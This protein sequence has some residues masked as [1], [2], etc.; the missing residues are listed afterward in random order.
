[1]IKANKLMVPRVDEIRTEAVQIIISR[2][3]ITK[4]AF[5]MRESMSQRVDYLEIKEDIFGKKT[6]KE[7][8]S[9]LKKRVKP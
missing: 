2:L 6:A 1:M 9:E 7:I 8:Y 5:F 3:G 4:A